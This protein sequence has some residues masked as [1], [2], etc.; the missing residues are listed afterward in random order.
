VGSGSV[1][2]VANGVALG[3]AATTNG[4]A[5]S[6]ALGPGA[7]P[8][9]TAHALAFAVNAA[10]VLPGTL[11][12]TLNGEARV[13]DAYTSLYTTTAGAGPTVLSATSSKMQYFTTAQTV[14]LP[15]VSTLQ[16]GFYFT[17]V[18]SA[19]GDLIIQSSGS[20]TV[21]TLSSGGW[22]EV[23]CILT[24]G[25]T[26]ASW[27]ARVGGAVT[28]VTAGGD[29]TGTYPN[30]TLANTAATPGTYRDAEYT[31]DAKGRITSITTRRV[32]VALTLAQFANAFTTPVLILPAPG[33]GSYYVIRYFGAEMT[34][35]SAALTG[36]SNLIL[37]YGSSGV[38][39]A[40]GRVAT[41]GGATADC[42]GWY[43]LPYTVVVGLGPRIDRSVVDNAPIYFKL[44][45]ADHGGGTGATFLLKVVYD[46]IS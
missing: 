37:I 28:G 32:T 16:L 9:D 22:A 15:V 40:S 41:F 11:G 20:D 34:Y 21:V 38:D 5:T 1:A 8:L 44:S 26:A 4:I 3:S 30:P 7:S 14:T 27:S 19:G 6:V 12:I 43:G 25:T 45:S 31:V 36:T 33:A 13:L 39:Y 23:A 18:N 42:V 2:N 17:I 10:S 35:G 24:S 46:I 29:L